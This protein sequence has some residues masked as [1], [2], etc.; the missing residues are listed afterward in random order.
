MFAG[1]TLD[2]VANGISWVVLVL[3]PVVGITVFWLVHILPEKVAETEAPS[4]GQGDPGAVPAVAGL[5]RAALAT[6]LALGL[7]EAGAAQDGLRHG[8]RATS[9]T[10]K[11]PTHRQRLRR[12]GRARA[13]IEQLRARLATLEAQAGREAR[14]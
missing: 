4:P 5:R 13:E 14:G 9:I 8:R 7:F 10:A 3:V 2:K 11:R 12:R 6:R 1:E